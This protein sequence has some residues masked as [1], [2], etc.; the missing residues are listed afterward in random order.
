MATSG[1][2]IVY[3]ENRDGNASVK[4]PQAKTLQRAYKVLNDNGI[5]IN[6]S[7]MDAGSYSEDIVSVAAKN[8]KLF[9]I[10]A[11]RTD[12]LTGRIRAISSWKTVEINY[13]KHQ[14]ASIPFISFMEESSFRL[15]VTLE[16][17]TDGQR[18]LFTGD[19][20]IYRCILT[21]DHESTEKEVV[22]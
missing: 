2:K 17:N 14:L 9:Y 16:K 19:D 4:T 22:E 11:N 21:N 10:R 15:I 8:C 1:D 18:D 6:R 3:V 13:K 5:K 12:A 20:F 7:R